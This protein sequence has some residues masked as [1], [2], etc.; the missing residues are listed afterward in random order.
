MIKRNKVNARYISEHAQDV[1]TDLGFDY[2]GK[3]FARTSSPIIFRNINNFYFIGQI[4]KMISLLV[5]MT[6]QIK[7]QYMI[8]L[9]KNDRNVN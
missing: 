6:K 9:H 7:L 4:D 8:S 1:Y 5:D 3:L 2:R